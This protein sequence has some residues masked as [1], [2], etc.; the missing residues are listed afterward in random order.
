MGGLIHVHR[1]WVYCL[2]LLF[3]LIIITSAIDIQL[4]KLSFL[5]WSIA[6]RCVLITSFNIQANVYQR[7]KDKA[8]YTPED[9]MLT[10]IPKPSA[11]PARSL[12]DDN[13]LQCRDSHSRGQKG[14]A[15]RKRHR[16]RFCHC[17]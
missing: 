11:S 13:G 12:H 15:T 14:H 8:F 7:H 17:T 2:L 6:H 5:Y 4:T 9:G 16:L 1:E 10:T 3:F